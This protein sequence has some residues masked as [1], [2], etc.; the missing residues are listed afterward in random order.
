MPVERRYVAS[1]TNLLGAR[2]GSALSADPEASLVATGII[3][4]T[5][6]VLAVR[7]PAGWRECRYRGDV[8]LVC[9][10]CGAAGVPLMFGLPVPEARAA[11]AAGQLALGGCIVA[12]DQPNWQCPQEHQWRDDERAWQKRLLAALVAHGYQEFAG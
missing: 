4:R 6:R 8:T 9:P 5:F 10:E 7:P 12:D 3:P 11:A 2:V 1:T